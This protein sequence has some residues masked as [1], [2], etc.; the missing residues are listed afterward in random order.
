[1][2]SWLSEDAPGYAG[3]PCAGTVSLAS[4]IYV[5]EEASST[6][7]TMLYDTESP[8]A[9]SSAWFITKQLKHA[10]IFGL[11]ARKLVLRFFFFL[12]MHGIV[13]TSHFAYKQQLAFYNLAYFF[14]LTGFYSV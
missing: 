8:A 13:T 6:R 10:D 14:Y 3:V 2:W 5:G 9:V 12:K 7:Q 1:M 4:Q 11:Y